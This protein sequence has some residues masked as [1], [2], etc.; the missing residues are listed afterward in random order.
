MCRGKPLHFE[1]MLLDPDVGRREHIQCPKKVILTAPMGSILMI[2]FGNP[3]QPPQTTKPPSKLS[4]SIGSHGINHSH[5][6][7]LTDKSTSSLS[8][9]NSP[10]DS[11][12]LTLTFLLLTFTALLLTSPPFPLPFQSFI[13]TLHFSSHIC[14]VRLQIFFAHSP[15]QLSLHSNHLVPL[16]FTIFQLLKRICSLRIDHIAS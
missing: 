16:K 14:F 3:M 9:F 6:C 10:F 4:K 5:G 13:P 8:T 7:P 11:P 15:F 12:P 1:A 2:K